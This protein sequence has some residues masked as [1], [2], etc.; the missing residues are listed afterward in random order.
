M[1][2]RLTTELKKE[3]SD[4]IDKV[5]TSALPWK[6]IIIAVLNRFYQTTNEYKLVYR[7]HRFDIIDGTFLAMVRSVETDSWDVYV[8]FQP[9]SKSFDILPSINV[10][11]RDLIESLPVAVKADFRFT[12]LANC[13][14]ELIDYGYR[15]VEL[16]EVVEEHHVSVWHILGDTVG[17]FISKAVLEEL[18]SDP[19]CA[20]NNELL[21]DLLSKFE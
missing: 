1:Q 6:D 21:V 7:A 18:N 2:R 19:G 3:I 15:L 16:P 13:F 8:A 11:V 12:M 14:R 9:Y 20:K 17:I 10:S 5:S 4:A